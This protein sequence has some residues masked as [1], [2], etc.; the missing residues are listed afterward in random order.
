MSTKLINIEEAMNLIAN[1]NG[2][3]MGI[4][5]AKVDGSIRTMNVKAKHLASLKGT[6]RKQPAHVLPLWSVNDN[7]WRS[8]RKDSLLSLT[9]KGRRYFV[10]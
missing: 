8:V 5:F 1:S 2:T 4:T 9:T 7:G 3:F 6:G 10:I